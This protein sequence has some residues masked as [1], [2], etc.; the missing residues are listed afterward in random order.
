MST[1]KRRVVW[2]EIYV[3]DLERAKAFYA[4]LFGWE[5]LPLTDYDPNYWTIDT[6]AES[7]GGALVQRSAL[8]QSGQGVVLYIEVDNLQESLDQAARLGATLAQP[9]TRIT[10]DAGS[11]ALIQD[12]DQ[13]LLGLWTA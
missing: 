3:T 13:N 8:S 7:V 5:F 4:E 11:F 2:F 10:S 12:L 6:G 9:P 1:H